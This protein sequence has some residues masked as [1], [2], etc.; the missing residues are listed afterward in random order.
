MSTLLRLAALT[1]VLC[2]MLPASAGE[3]PLADRKSGYA[4]M[5]R[6]IQTMQDDDSAN[7]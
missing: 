7:P 6:E 2:S 4:L 5:A 1:T 3:I